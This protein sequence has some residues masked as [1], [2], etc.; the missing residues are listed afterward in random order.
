LQ[1]E[2]VIFFAFLPQ[3]FGFKFMLGTE[4]I[5]DDRRASEE[6]NGEKFEELN[7]G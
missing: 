2:L 6:V 7:N 4:L 3:W 5:S 1:G